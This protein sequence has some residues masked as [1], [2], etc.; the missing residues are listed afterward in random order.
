MRHATQPD[1][2]SLPTLKNRE[3]FLRVQKHGKKWVSK[4]LILQIAEN[5]CEHMRTGYTVTKRTFKSAVK[6]NRIKRRLRA[7]SYDIL[8]AHAKTGYDYILIGRQDTLTRPY[9][10]LLKD[11]KWCLK[12]LELS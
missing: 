12:R 2:Q 3:D 10:D 1:I 4:S 8:P 5:E 6:R 9:D 11:L 7:V